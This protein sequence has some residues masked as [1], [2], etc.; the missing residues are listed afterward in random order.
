MLKGS[1]PIQLER[2]EKLA[3]RNLIKFKNK[4]PVLHLRKNRTWLAA[5]QLC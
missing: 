2:L 4:C 1:I 3:N 5:E